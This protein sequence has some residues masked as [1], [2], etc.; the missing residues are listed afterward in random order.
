MNKVLILAKA[1]MLENARKQIFHV[2]TL[3]TLT[4]VCASTLLSVFTM[5]LQVKILKDLC[6]SSILF[7]GGILAI[8]LSS[9]VIPGE[10]ESRTCYPILARPMRRFQFILGKYL[11]TLLT[12]YSGLL[13]IGFAFATLLAARGALDWLIFLA[14]GYTFLEVAVVAA[15]TMCLST[16][17]TPAGA[18][19]ISFMIYV[20]GTIKITYFRPLVNNITNPVSKVMVTFVYHMLPN[21]ES[22]NFKDALVH[23]LGVPHGYLIQVAV[24]GVCFAALALTVASHAF[25]KREL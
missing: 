20:A 9:A 18:A 12:I 11:G 15:I 3:L 22:F 1:T 2:V 8:T 23:R 14:I 21:L 19:M 6:M 10:I 13:V 17:M 25:A 7:C 24:Y 5:G 16:V 4:I